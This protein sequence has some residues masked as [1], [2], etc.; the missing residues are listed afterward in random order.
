MTRRLDEE[1]YKW[2]CNFTKNT[3]S[4]VKTIKTYDKLLEILYYHEFIP[5]VPHD[6]NRAE[7]GIS[8]R[9]RFSREFGVNYNPDEKCSILEMMIALALRCEEQ[10]MDDPDIGN[11]TSYWFWLMIRNM[12]LFKYS[13]D[14]FTSKTTNIIEDKLDI[15]INREYE[16]NGKGGLFVIENCK[17]DLRTVEIWYQM[18]WFLDDLI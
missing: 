4:K 18:C 5:I 6:D 7:D 12:G 8:L 2:L 9:W 17:Y 16:C 13:D 15:F 11:R 10:I 3:N 14:K 1:Y